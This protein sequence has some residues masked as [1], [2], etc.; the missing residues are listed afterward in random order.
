[1][2]EDGQWAQA[3]LVDF[4]TAKS[5]IPGDIQPGNYIIRHEIIALHQANEVGGCEFYPSCTNV[6]VNSDGDKVPEDTVKFPGG[7]DPEEA[8]IYTPELYNEQEGVRV[9]LKEE[10]NADDA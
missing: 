6:Y 1:M 9:L 2:G 10:S 5:K 7:Y 3:S 8:G 4:A